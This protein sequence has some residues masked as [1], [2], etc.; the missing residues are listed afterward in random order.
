V[1]SNGNENSGYHFSC[2]LELT[3][4]VGSYVGVQN[5]ERVDVL[6]KAL[7][8]EYD[9]SN[10]TKSLYTRVLNR[11]EG[12]SCQDGSRCCYISGHRKSRRLTIEL[13]DQGSTLMVGHPVN[14]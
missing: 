10:K 3:K 2:R 13:T 11:P 6:V 1:P 8:Y 4:S 9:A 12:Q 14:S 5:V 7:F